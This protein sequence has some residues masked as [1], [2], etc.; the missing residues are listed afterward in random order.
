MKPEFADLRA[1]TSQVTCAQQGIDYLTEIC[2][3]WGRHIGLLRVY[4]PIFKFLNFNESYTTL[5]G[6]SMQVSLFLAIYVTA[7]KLEINLESL[8]NAVFI[9]LV[10]ISPP[11]VLLVERGQLEIILFIFILLSAYL[12]YRSRNTVAYLLLAFISILKL[13]PIFLLGILIANRR[14]AQSKL[15]KIFGICIFGA[16]LAS[17][18]LILRNEG[19][20]LWSS[21]VSG[22]AYRSFGITVPLFVLE[23]FNNY[24]IFPFSIHFTLMQ[25]Q[26]LGIMI[27][28][29]ILL[30]LQFLHFRK[31]LFLLDSSFLI[32]GATFSSNIF[33]FNLCLVYL[34]YFLISSNDYRMIYLVPLFLVGLVNVDVGERRRI[35]NFFVYGVTI[36]MWSQIYRPTSAL[37]QIPLLVA[38][39]LVFLNIAPGLWTIYSRKKSDLQMPRS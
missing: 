37:V 34:S 22:S 30:I 31:K 18:L 35:S 23:R 11:I 25:A 26:I 36:L 15:E 9:L 38:L 14:I 20:E 17:V 32:E 29:A 39:A 6:L 1:Y 28:G 4:V 8:K 27:F 33:L 13:Y 5:I 2:D 24:Q 19:Q 7:Y 16:A 10:L 21:T 3:P 12:V